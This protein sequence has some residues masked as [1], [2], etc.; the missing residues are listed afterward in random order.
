MEK[1]KK[2]EYLVIIVLPLVMLLYS[3]FSMPV[4]EIFNN[5]LKLSSNNWSNIHN[6]QKPYNM[7]QGNIW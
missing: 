5:L 2:K 1:T 4:P 3:I 7:V 6:Y